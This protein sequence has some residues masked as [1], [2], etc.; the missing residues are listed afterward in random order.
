MPEAERM[1]GLVPRVHISL[2]GQGPLC[3]DPPPTIGLQDF[4]AYRDFKATVRTLLTWFPSISVS[5]LWSLVICSPLVSIL[6]VSRRDEQHEAEL[7]GP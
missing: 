4:R 3:K 6:S 1:C 7:A 5:S 2:I